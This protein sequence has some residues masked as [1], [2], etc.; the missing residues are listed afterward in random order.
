[1]YNKL[2]II[3]SKGFLII[4]S[5]P[6][7]SGKTTVYK[8]LL[9]RNE[10]FDYSIST[11]TRPIRDN[12]VDGV[13]YSFVSRDEFDKMIVNDEF[14]EYAEVHGNMYGT[15]RKI[16]DLALLEKRVLLF[17]IDVAG[18]AQIR[19]RYTSDTVS[20]FIVPPSF[21]ELIRRLEDRGTDT[22]EVIDLRMHNA[23]L[24]FARLDEYDYIVINDEL[25]KCISDI[26]EII[27]SESLRLKRINKVNWLKGE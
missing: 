8:K 3:D 4:L 14:A 11:T 15:S 7:G 18:N 1:M 16:V 9:Q 21:E 22:K 24:E 6:S 23:K 20:I 13:D 10:Q 25:N 2:D 19:E 27:R 26:E 5:A 12:E 17:D